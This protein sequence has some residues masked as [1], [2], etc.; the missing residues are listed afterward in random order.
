MASIKNYLNKFVDPVKNQLSM[1]KK[2]VH[3]S[4]KIGKASQIP[5]NEAYFAYAAVMRDIAQSRSWTFYEA[6]IG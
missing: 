2:K 3:Q 4:N 1:A 6:I 5:K